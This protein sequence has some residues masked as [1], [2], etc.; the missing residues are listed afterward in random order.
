[1]K[2]LREIYRSAYTKCPKTIKGRL[3]KLVAALPVK[4]SVKSCSVPLPERFPNTYKGALVISADFEMAWAW[5]YAK[6][7]EDPVAIGLRE[8]ANVPGILQIFD[9]YQ[10][11]ISWATVG[12]L[13][14][15]DCSCEGDFAHPE[16]SHIP[17]FTNKVWSFESGDWFDHDPCTDVDKDPAWYAPDL[18]E[19][20]INAKAEHEIA[21]HTFSHL[22]CTSTNCPQQVIED[23]IK[24]CVKLA[25]EFG[26]ILKSMVFPGGTNGYYPILKENGFTNVRVNADYDLFYPEKDSSGL[27]LLPSTASI[28]NH[29]FGWSAPEYRQYYTRFLDKALSANTVC[30]LWFHP[31]IDAFCMNE[32]LPIVLEE[33]SNRADRGDLWI[34]TMGEL[35]DFCEKRHG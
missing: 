2:K 19:A 35:A 13:F 16:I 12:H 6:G 1:M 27:W 11:P 7:V 5:R 14:L 9:E 32:I 18:I 15:Q 22:D 30:H 20:I 23:E 34:V 33:A 25:S 10:F 21:C 24:I 28:E 31:S 26:V 3:T 17:H 29:G 8:R 4:P